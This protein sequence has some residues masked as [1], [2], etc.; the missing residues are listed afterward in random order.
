[1]VVNL[2]AE[3][4]DGMK[5]NIKGWI[6]KNCGTTGVEYSLLAAGI[7]LTIALTTF[8]FGAEIANFFDS[9]FEEWGDR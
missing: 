4:G 8:A 3:G 2:N 1:M 6:V 7:S 5:Q 9:F